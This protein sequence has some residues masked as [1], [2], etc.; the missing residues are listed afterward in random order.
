M[1]YTLLNS[2]KKYLQD[3]YTLAT[4]ETYYKRLSSLFVGQSLT[5]TIAQLD[6]DKILDHLKQIKYKNHFSQYKNA[7][8]HFCEFQDI[9]L[10]FEV[11]EKIKELAASTK[12]KYRNLQ[13]INY[14]AIDKKIKHIKNKKLK[15]SYQ[16]M[17][18]TGLRVSELASISL[19]DCIIVDDK[20]IFN[21]QEKGGTFEIMAICQTEYPK[22]YADIEWLVLNTKANKKIFYSAIYLQIKAKELNF[23]CHDLRRIYAHIEYKKTKSK[24]TVMKKLRHTNIKNTNKYLRTRVKF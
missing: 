24:E 20:I 17:L 22:L 23:K 13:A 1:I 15:I 16:T 8:L 11:L 14:P 4:S 6:F 5:D 18:A 2:Y 21:F 7:L 10:P 12:K 9:I 3:K 19:S